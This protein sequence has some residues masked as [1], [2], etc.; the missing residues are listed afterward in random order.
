MVPLLPAV[1]VRAVVPPVALIVPPP[2]TA[3]VL[4]E[5]ATLPLVADRLPATLTVPTEAVML[6]KLRVEPD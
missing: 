1:A 2:L 4:D 6:S 5:M 3:R